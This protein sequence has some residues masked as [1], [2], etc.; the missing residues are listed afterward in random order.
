MW[1]CICLAIGQIDSH[2]GTI[3]APPPTG[4]SPTGARIEVGT[5][6]FGEAGF[7]M[8]GVGREGSGREGGGKG[9]GRGREEDRSEVGN[10]AKPSCV[11]H[12]GESV[13]VG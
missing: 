11:M 4:T 6:A 12:S 13:T 9:E 10:G 5:E 2:D 7:C 3:T 1:H 8:Q